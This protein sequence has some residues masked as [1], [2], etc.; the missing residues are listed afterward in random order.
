MDYFLRNC[1][2]LKHFSSETR[3]V[4]I[5]ALVF[6]SNLNNLLSRKS[7]GFPQINLISSNQL[8]IKETKHPRF[9]VLRFSVSFSGK[10]FNLWTW[11][12]HGKSADSLRTKAPWFSVRCWRE[13]SFLS[14][15]F[16]RQHDII[17]LQRGLQRIA[18]AKNFTLEIGF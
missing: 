4:N 13:N 11:A 7:N 12:F 2:L 17:Y 6:A 15:K 8:L 14:E 16:T 10:R 1:D 9:V 3:R 5:F 18:G